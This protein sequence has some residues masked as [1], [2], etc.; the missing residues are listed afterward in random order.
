MINKKCAKKKQHKEKKKK[1]KRRL[2]WKTSDG[3]RL[4]AQR[5]DDI[6][7]KEV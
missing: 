1:K 6:P 3:S 4:V 7:P 2:L 5:P